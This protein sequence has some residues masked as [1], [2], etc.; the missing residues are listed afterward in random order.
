VGP[1]LW[2]AV[3]DTPER[4]QS[5]PASRGPNGRRRLPA[6]AHLGWPRWSAAPP[7]ARGKS[8]PLGPRSPLKA[9]PSIEAPLNT[10]CEGNE[11]LAARQEGLS[12]GLL[13]S[14]GLTAMN[15]AT[16]DRC[17]LPRLVGREAESGSHPLTGAEHSCFSGSDSRAQPSA[18]R[19]GDRRPTGRSDAGSLA[20]AED[21]V[22][23]LASQFHDLAKTVRRGRY[24]RGL[25]V[26]LAG[27]C[28][29]WNRPYVARTGHPPVSEVS[30]A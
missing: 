17:R 10:G 26:Q 2:K 19:R 18:A 7:H 20:H 5:E 21:A 6:R 3:L 22:A 4:R 16:Q 23:V 9:S 14:P 29:W 12:R 30:P 27:F 15:T 13:P 25:A 28:I 11:E 8:V 1:S 24:F